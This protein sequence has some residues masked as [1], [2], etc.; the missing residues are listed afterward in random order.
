M[1]KNNKKGFTLAELLIVV[2]IIAVLVAV[3]IP[4]FST[5]LEKSRDAVTTSNLR[6]A[7]A[8]AMTEMI[9]ESTNTSKAYPV[10]CKGTKADEDLSGTAKELPFTGD[11]I[12]T[13]AGYTSA[14][15][16]NVSFSIDADDKV[17][18]SIG[19]GSETPEEP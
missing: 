8:E 4:V 6:A 16:V 12:K 10:A 1:K 5:Q 2:A 14:Q 13:I 11:A 18:A 7:Y 17:T 9:S 15:V 3:A 19:S